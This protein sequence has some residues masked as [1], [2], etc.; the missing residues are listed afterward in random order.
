MK[1]QT[2]NPEVLRRQHETR[3][4]KRKNTPGYWEAELAGHRRRYAD[5][6]EARQRMADKHRSR[7]SGCTPEMSVALRELQQ[8]VCAMPGCGV[9][10]LQR[11]RSGAGECADHDHRTGKVRG[12]LCRACNT[13]LGHYEKLRGRAELYLCA[14]PA[15]ELEQRG[16]RR[17][18]IPDKE[19]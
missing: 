11:N 18:E 15:G 17:Y 19:H 10:M 9:V 6:P 16:G 5:N 12:L 4:S 8:G 3:A 14:P 2:R 13:S 7:Y 1:S